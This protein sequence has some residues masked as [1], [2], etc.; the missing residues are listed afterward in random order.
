MKNQEKQTDM[1]KNENKVNSYIWRSKKE[2]KRRSSA[3]E[4]QS[5]IESNDIL[6]VQFDWMESITWQQL[7]D[8]LDRQY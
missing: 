4:S 3:N 2:K 5:D 7:L 6:R 1:F 8:P